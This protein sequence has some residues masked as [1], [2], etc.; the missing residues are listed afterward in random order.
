MAFSFSIYWWMIPLAISIIGLIPVLTYRSS[1]DYD[2]GA[3]LY[4]ILWL[5]ASVAAWFVAIVMRLAT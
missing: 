5:A 3:S 4:F 2:F 1:H